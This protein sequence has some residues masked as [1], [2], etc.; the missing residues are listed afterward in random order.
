MFSGVSGIIDKIKGS[1]RTGLREVPYDGYIAELHKGEMVLTAAEA[2]QYQ[3]S[4][5]STTVS[6]ITVNN[7]SPKALTEAE[8]ARQFRKTQRKLQLGF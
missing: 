6:N 1:H 4:S 2:N 7:Y 5:G 3:K 8:T